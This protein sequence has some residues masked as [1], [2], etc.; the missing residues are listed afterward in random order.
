VALVALYLAFRSE[1][2]NQIR[3]EQQLELSR[4]IAT[5]NVRPLLARTVSG[6]LDRKA[7]ELSNH[8]AG[9]AI[10]RKVTFRRGKRSAASV[11]DLLELEQAVVW[12]DFTELG[13]SI[14][15]IPAKTSETIVE[16]TQDHLL[17]QGF[18]ARAAAALLEELEKQL[19]E[20]QVTATYNDVLGNMIAEN[21]ELP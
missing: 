20:V 16:L 4:R 19:D 13:S 12:D 8:G 10:L 15:Y 11:L 1:R 3:F 5:A 18:S 2:R 6:Y 17:G 21:E 14:S 9:T 7:L